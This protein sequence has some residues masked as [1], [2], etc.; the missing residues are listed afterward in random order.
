MHF[1]GDEI[2]CLPAA[3]G[4]EDRDERGAH[5]REEIERYWPIEHGPQ[6]RARWIGGSVP[7]THEYERGDGC[8][9]HHHQDALHRAARAHAEAIDDREAREHECGDPAI[10]NRDR[11]HG[12]KIF[13]ECHSYRSHSSGLNYQ[14][15]NPAVK[16]R[17]R[18]MIGLAQVRI[19]AAGTGHARGEFRIDKSTEQR[20][21]A[22]D[23][24]SAEDQHGRVD[25]LCDDVRIDENP[26]ADDA[27]HDDHRGVEE[28]EARD[29]LAGRRH[30]FVLGRVCGGTLSLP[31]KFQRLKSRVSRGGLCV[32][33]TY[34]EA[35]SRAC[36][37]ARGKG[38]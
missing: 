24:P 27:A 14:Q 16:K 34:R 37:R 5:G 22:A 36:L 8:D 38:A 2:G 20:D 23:G 32:G 21:C 18:W 26:G 13:C 11:R 10:R 17:D 3:V 12:V 35:A 1:G 9:F 15:Q 6:A 30:F 29:E 31:T 33:I 28:P 7:E 19:L 4:E 25:L